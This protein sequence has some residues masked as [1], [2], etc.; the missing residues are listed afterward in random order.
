[1]T[2]SDMIEKFLYR[3][4]GFRFSASNASVVGL[5]LLLHL[6]ASA[7]LRSCGAYTSP[8]RQSRLWKRSIARACIWS[9]S[10]RRK[11][12][13]SAVVILRD[14]LMVATVVAVR[15]GWVRV[16]GRTNEI[17]MVNYRPFARAKALYEDRQIAVGSWRPPSCF[18]HEF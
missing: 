14:W 9:C 17:E 7:A 11:F 12:S 4:N 5:Y 13:R 18:N 3:S 6:R 16:R 15:I 1:V 10:L 2:Y 8:E